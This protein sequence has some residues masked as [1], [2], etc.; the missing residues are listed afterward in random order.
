MLH[1]ATHAGEITADLARLGEL[2]GP[3]DLLIAGRTVKS[4]AV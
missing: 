4:K 3:Y 2:I 1:A